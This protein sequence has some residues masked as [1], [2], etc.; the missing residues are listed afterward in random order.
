MNILSH[1]E[2][3]AT[4]PVKIKSAATPFDPEYQECLAKRKSKR[5]ARNSWVDP[6]LTA[7]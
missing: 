6:A 1:Y 5:Q 4:S 7:L 3:F 2:F